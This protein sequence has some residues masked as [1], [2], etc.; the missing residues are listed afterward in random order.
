ME[1]GLLPH[2]R[3]LD[4]HEELEEERRLCYVGVTRAEQRLYLMRAFRRTLMGGTM[5]SMPSRF[6]ADIPPNLIEPTIPTP[7][8]QWNPQS[9]QE[10]RKRS[11]PIT[12]FKAGEKVRHG[13]FGEG[14]VVNCLPA[15]LDYEITVAFKGE[16]GVK[17]LLLSFAGLEKI[18]GKDTA[19]P[20]A[21]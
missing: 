4:T 3:S 15:N 19:P 17:R 11:V 18:D 9:S 6:L 16:S 20:L 14:I 12:P 21:P 7:L 8:S 1:E 5:A 13:Q 2:M 10:Q